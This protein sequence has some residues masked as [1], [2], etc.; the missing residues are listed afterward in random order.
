MRGVA[1][2]PYCQSRQSLTE[3][4]AKSSLGKANIIQ[5]TSSNRNESSYNIPLLWSEEKKGCRSAVSAE[6]RPRG[7]NTSIWDSRSRPKPHKATHRE[8]VRA[9]HHTMQIEWPLGKQC[10]FGIKVWKQRIEISTLCWRQTAQEFSNLHQSRWN[11]QSARRTTRKISRKL[12]CGWNKAIQWVTYIVR[13]DEAKVA[14]GRIAQHAADFEH[15][16]ADCSPSH[17]DSTL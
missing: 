4:N 11:E 8:R 6:I 10:T 2:T 12:Q 15:L 5:A 13:G 16:I 1:P 14:F 3:A 17:S 7:S 9:C